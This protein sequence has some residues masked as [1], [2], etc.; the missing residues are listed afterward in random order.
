[1]FQVVGL[2]REFYHYIAWGIL[3]GF[4]LAHSYPTLIKFVWILAFS[5]CCLLKGRVRAIPTIIV[6]VLLIHVFCQYLFEFFWRNGS[7]RFVAVCSYVGVYFQ[8]EENPFGHRIPLA[9]SLTLVIVSIMARFRGGIEHYI[10]PEFEQLLAIR[11][12]RAICALLHTFLPVFVDLMLFIATMYNPSIFGWFSFCVLAISVADNNFMDKRAGVVGLSFVICFLA[13]Y[14]LFLGYPVGIFADN[15]RWKIVT[16]DTR[17]YNWFLF[18]GIYE[19]QLSALSSN[20]FCAWICAFYRQ[21]RKNRLINY[22][23]RFQ[24]MPFGLRRFVQGVTGHIYEITVA[25]VVVIGAIIRSIDGLLFFVLS[26][27]LLSRQILFGYDKKATL[28]IMSRYT[29]FLVALRML[30][31]LPIFP[32]SE[33]VEIVKRAFDL[34][35]ESRSISDAKWVFIFLLLRLSEHIMGTKLYDQADR[36]LK[37]HSGFRFIRERQL[38]IIERLDQEIVVAK[39][40]IEIGTVSEEAISEP[41]FVQAEQSKFDLPL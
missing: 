11:M 20:F 12:Y 16:S 14:L 38:R 36:T 41:G 30:S 37:E 7:E 22:Q 1:L 39:R 25:A 13:Q 21:F 35:F 23:Q 17:R 29:L 32:S 28:A 27:L 9:F 19:V 10:S 24:A 5:I 31:R 2:F 6:F 40:N 26:A 3:F 33:F 34:P 18:L 8:K 4:S 15:D